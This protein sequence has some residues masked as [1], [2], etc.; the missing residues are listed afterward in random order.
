MSFIVKGLKL[1]VYSVDTFDKE[2]E[3]VAYSQSTIFVEKAGGCGGKRAS[4]MAV[5][6]TAP[7]QGTKPDTSITESTHVDQV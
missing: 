4:D 1:F 6:P 7:S 3:K 2:G 5:Q